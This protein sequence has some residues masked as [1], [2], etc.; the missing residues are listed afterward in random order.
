MIK[1]TIILFI[2]VYSLYLLYERNDMKSEYRTLENDG[3]MILRNKTKEEVLKYLPNG[4]V[5]INYKYVIKGCSIST[6]HRDVTSSQYIFKTTHPVY[7][8]TVYHN[9]GDLL[10][11]SPN[12]HKTVPFLWAQS[13]IVSG[14][15]KTGI[16]FNSD[17]IHSGAINTFGENR[18]AEQFKICHVDDL[19]TLKHLHGINKSSDGKC[20]THYVYIYLLRKLSLLFPYLLNHIFTDL[21]QKKPSEDSVVSKIINDYFIGDFYIE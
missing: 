19:P 5:F 8:Y 7:T 16:L 12:S 11:L 13:Y 1:K 9:T 18:Y 14:R 10:S 15:E 17:I 21:L 6:F 4:Y 20:N 3:Y 2:T